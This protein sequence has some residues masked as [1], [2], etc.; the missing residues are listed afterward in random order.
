MPDEEAVMEIE[1]AAFNLNSEKLANQTFEK[2]ECLDEKCPRG[3]PA[4]KSASFGQSPA[5]FLG[6]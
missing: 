3:F 5:A 6:S 4:G 1:I 2:L